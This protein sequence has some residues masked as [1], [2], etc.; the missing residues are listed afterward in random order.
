MNLLINEINLGGRN[1]QAGWSQ[2]NK[3]DKLPNKRP[4]APAITLTIDRWT[5]HDNL[6]LWTMS[7]SVPD[8][9]DNINAK[10][11]LMMMMTIIIRAGGLRL[12]RS[13]ENANL[14][15]R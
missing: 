5:L 6:L 14:A 11:M 13:A 9:C 4:D 12:L 8:G 3:M 2:T 15:I 10:M 1:R 7:K